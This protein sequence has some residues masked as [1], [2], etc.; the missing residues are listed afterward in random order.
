[1]GYCL[2]EAGGGA[3]GGGV[4]VF[5][6]GD[7]VDFGGGG[8]GDDSGGAGGLG[9]FAHGVGVDGEGLGVVAGGEGGESA[10]D[11]AGGDD[12]ECLFEGVAGAFDAGELVGGEH[13]VGQEDDFG[14][15]AGAGGRGDVEDDV[16]TRVDGECSGGLV[17][18]GDESGGGECEDDAV[19]GGGGFGEGFDV[20][21]GDFS[22]VVGGFDDGSGLVGVDVDAGGV[23]ADGGDDEAVAEGLELVADV[24]EVGVL[25]EEHDFEV[26]DAGAGGFGGDGGVSVGGGVGFL[27]VVGGGCG[28]GVDGGW[29]VVPEAGE[30][31]GLAEG[32]AGFG[33]GFSLLRLLGGVGFGVGGG[34]DAGGAEELG[35]HVDA[36]GGRRPHH[37]NRKCF[38]FWWLKAGVGAGFYGA[39]AYF[40]E[41]G[42]EEEDEALGTGVDHSGVAEN[43]E[44]G[45]GVGQGDGGG[46]GGGG[47]HVDKRVG[48][49][50]VRGDGGSPQDGDDGAFDGFDNGVVD[51]F[52]GRGECLLH[53][54]S[55]NPVGD[56]RLGE[57]AENLTQHHAGVAAG[58]LHRT[59]GNS[60]GELGDI[61]LV[62]CREV[63]HLGEGGLHGVGHV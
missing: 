24:V 22:E 54:A 39:A 36:S 58:A 51:E 12:G 3:E 20:E 26:V 4:A 15:A 1:M 40:V 27:P 45:W 43:G 41:H 42:F 60:R 2:V 29:L 16:V 37:F 18:V 34:G 63:I 48:G 10:D 14:G 53:G 19:A 17:E 21:V 33:W 7:G 47:E 13:A 52:I 30:L 57:P 11:G 6:V 23:G 38:Q 59:N 31:G 32:A 8:V 5:V 49:G 55:G 25:D 62:G 50:L 56:C 28:W 35:E 46:S 9:G 61:A 44:L